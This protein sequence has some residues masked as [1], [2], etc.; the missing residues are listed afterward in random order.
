ME[1]SLQSLGF[2]LVALLVESGWR[3]GRRGKIKEI[4]Q[5]VPSA[6]SHLGNK[7]RDEHVNGKL[8]VPS[9]VFAEAK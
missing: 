1:N 8:S 4:S 3:W 2:K 7:E 5:F 9:E 6:G